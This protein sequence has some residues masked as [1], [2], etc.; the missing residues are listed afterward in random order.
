MA[1][2][3]NIGDFENKFELSTGMYSNSKLQNYIDRYEDIYLVEMLGVELYNQFI[4]DLNLQ[5]YPNS[6]KFIKLFNPFN[7]QIS[8]TLMISKGMKDM[9][10]GFIYF[11][12]LKDLVTQ[13]TSVGVTKPQEQNSKVI[14]SHTTI[15]GRYNESIKTYNAIQEYILFNMTDY[16][17]FKGVQKLY[18]YWI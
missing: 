11:E 12:Y 14:T 15:Y 6:N 2:F 1:R 8:F 4:A 16:A 5:N 10:V 3:V 13:T 17:D 9:L 18:A 7:E